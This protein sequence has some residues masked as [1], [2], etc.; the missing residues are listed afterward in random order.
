MRL[1][2]PLMNGL[3]DPGMAPDEDL[4]IRNFRL[5]EFADQMSLNLC[6]AAPRFATIELGTSQLR[7][8]KKGSGVFSIEP[9]PFNQDVLELEIKGKRLP[10]RKFAGST[11]LQEMFNSEPESTERISVVKRR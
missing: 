6:F 5:L 3:A 2:I 4:L 1:D 7:I 9:W 11:E 10:K 8:E